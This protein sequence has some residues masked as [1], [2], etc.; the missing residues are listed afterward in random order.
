MVR[1]DPGEGS[2]EA[3]AMGYGV[4]PG[5]TTRQSVADLADG[6]YHLIEFPGGP[7]HHDP[8][9]ALWFAPPKSQAIKALYIDR[10]FAIRA[11]K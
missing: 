4:S 8:G 6:E 9:V 10:V 11:E 7:Y 3:R 2:P 5:P 1:I